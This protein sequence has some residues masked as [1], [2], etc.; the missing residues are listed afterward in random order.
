MS[1]RSREAVIPLRRCV[2]RRG[3]LGKV[4]E[5]AVFNREAY[6]GRG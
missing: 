5:V 6:Q 2:L 4:P 3:R 1:K